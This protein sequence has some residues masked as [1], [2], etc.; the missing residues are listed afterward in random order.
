MLV[1]ARVR[2]TRPRSDRLAPSSGSAKPRR[3]RALQRRRD[4]APELPRVHLGLPRLRV[5]GHDRAGGVGPVARAALGVGRGEHVDDRVR[6][7][8]LAAVLLDLPEQR[9]LGADRE[10][11]LAPGLVEEHQLEQTGAVVHD[12]VDDRALAVARA[13]RPDRP[14]LG[15]DGGLV[16]DRQLG[17]LGALG[18]VD[19]AARVVVEQVEHR[20]DPHVGQPGFE[21][22]PDRL[23]LVDAVRRELPQGETRRHRSRAI[24]RRRGTGRAAGHRSAARA[25]RRDARTRGAR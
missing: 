24:R 4:R 16:A 7:L 9:H 14:D 3:L 1:Y 23:E 12:R 19:V 18:A 20:R 5:D 17:D 15:V 8:A 25:R 21:L 13:T 22:R 11:P 10:L 2:S 6:E